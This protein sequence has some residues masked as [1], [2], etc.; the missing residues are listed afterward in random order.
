LLR[1]RA[2]FS[3]P[4]SRAFHATR[5]HQQRDLYDILGVGKSAEK[6]E[7]KKAY[8]KLAKKCHPDTNKDDPEAAK[9]FNEITAAYEVLADDDQRTRYDQFG[10]A[11]VD[12][13]FQGN[14]G[15]N[16]F[17][18]GFGGGGGYEG[19]NMGGGFGI[20]PSHSFVA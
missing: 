2:V 15:Q 18:G 12:P 19:E 14:Q 3:R 20:S 5:S 11:G 4:P 13:N 9:K 10:H 6:S 7:V 16:P 1:E 8:Y 17:G